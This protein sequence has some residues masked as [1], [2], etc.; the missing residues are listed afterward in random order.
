MTKAEKLKLKKVEEVC[1]ELPST[2]DEVWL[3]SRGF[4]RSA[5]LYDWMAR[6][7]EYIE[8]DSVVTRTKGIIGASLY[9]KKDTFGRRKF[10]WK[11]LLEIV[12]REEWMDH[13]EIK[14]FRG[15]YRATPQAALADV[16]DKLPGPYK[17][18]VRPQ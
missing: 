1:P 3:V 7:E 18:R 2:Q 13:N 12:Y 4:H 15:V 5:L 17:W 11:A 9:L 6:L 8:G 10:V 14:P 16:M